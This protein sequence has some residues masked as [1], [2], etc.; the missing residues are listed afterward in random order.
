[1]DSIHPSVEVQWQTLAVS[2]DDRRKIKSHSSAIIWLTGIPASGKTTIAR[3]LEK[4]LY[5]MGG[6]TYV[7]DGDNVRHG[8]TRDLGFSKN[9]RK[10]NIRRIAEVAKL[11]CDAGIITICSFVSPY[12]DDRELARNLVEESEFIEVFV[13]CPV[14]VCMQRDPK[15]MY[16]KAIKGKMKAFTGVDDPYEVPESPEF[17]IETDSLPLSESVEKIITYL[18]DKGVFEESKYG[19]RI[20]EAG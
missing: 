2:K 7:L 15:S 16:S 13:K 4:R 20:E 9:E 19:F 6:H 11:F 1:M 5:E 14:E 3:E 10:E 8:L 12:R 18:K 17:V